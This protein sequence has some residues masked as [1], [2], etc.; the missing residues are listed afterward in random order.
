M[1]LL[2]GPDLHINMWIWFLVLWQ[3]EQRE[4]EQTNVGEKENI[5]WIINTRNKWVS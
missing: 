3:H 5:P 4:Y 1:L 2:F